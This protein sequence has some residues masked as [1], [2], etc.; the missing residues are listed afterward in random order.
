MYLWAVQNVLLT[1]RPWGVW[2]WSLIVIG[3]RITSRD[4]GRDSA[5]LWDCVRVSWLLSWTGHMIIVLVR[6][7]L[8]ESSLISGRKHGMNELHKANTRGSYTR[9]TP[10]GVT[11]EHQGEIQSNT[12]GRNRRTPGAVQANTRGSLHIFVISPFVF[13]W[14]QLSCFVATYPIEL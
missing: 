12:R 9:Q 11:S 10:G 1:L 13:L 2:L 4:T 5:V 8:S 6:T 7:W 3:W 14:I